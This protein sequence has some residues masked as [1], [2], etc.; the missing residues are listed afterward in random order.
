MFHR[1]GF[2]LKLDL[3]SS[4]WWWTAGKIRLIVGP[5]SPN[6]GTSSDPC[7]RWPT[8]VATSSSVDSSK[9]TSQSCEGPWFEPRKLKTETT[10]LWCRRQAIGITFID[11]SNWTTVKDRNELVTDIKPASMKIF[12]IGCHRD[13]E[14]EASV[15]SQKVQKMCQKMLILSPDLQLTQAAKILALAFS[16][17]DLCIL[18][19]KQIV[20]YNKTRGLIFEL[21]G[22]YI[23]RQLR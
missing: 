15:V 19:W 11:F 13:W 20:N 10:W 22:P 4:S 2:S 5:A 18:L 9:A 17:I 6:S 8:G 16:R 21:E 3:I 1:I 12:K 7:S 23:Q 14:P